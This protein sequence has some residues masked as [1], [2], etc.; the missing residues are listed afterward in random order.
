[1][2]VDV[3]RNVVRVTKHAGHVLVTTGALL[4]WIG[5]WPWYTSWIITTVVILIA[6][7]VFLA[8]A[9]SPTL[10]KLIAPD[11][12]RIVLVKKLK[13]SLFIYLIITMTMLW[14][15]VAKPNLWA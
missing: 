6:S 10:R 15:M 7:L 1:M 8:R 13:R 2:Y 12:N 9:F 3:F 4:A 11:S 5:G 14:F